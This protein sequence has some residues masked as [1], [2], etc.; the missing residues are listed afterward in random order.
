M[1]NESQAEPVL[2][3]DILGV[4]KVY[5]DGSVVHTHNDP[6]LNTA[7][8]EKPLDKDG[9]VASK[10]VI[11]DPDIDLWVRIYL[12]PQRRTHMPVI[13]YFHGGGFCSISPSFSWFHSFCLK[14]T[15][16]VDA[17]IVSVNYRLAP[18]HRLPTAYN[19]SEAAIEWV[20]FQLIEK[21]GGKAA[22]PWLN[23]H[24]EFSNVYLMGDSSGANIVH[25]LIM[26]RPLEN[27]KPL[28]IRGALLLQPYFAGEEYT[29]SELKCPETA[30][31]NMK[32]HDILWSLALPLGA[33]RDHP[34]CN[35][36]S[37]QSP[38]LS[39][40]DIPPLMAFVGDK[41]YGRDR[42][43]EYCNALKK[44]GKTVD[45]IMFDEEEHAF[46]LL[47]AGGENSKKIRQYVASFISSHSLA[48]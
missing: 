24:A 27:W 44:C 15:S 47:K 17:I 1:A 46:Y 4:L 3:E 36:F 30:F 28:Q 35:P 32:V 6:D 39:K 18:E 20:R 37:P 25:H 26:R 29:E 33:N 43:L 12:P 14:M 7:A 41:C 42:S 40:A 38:S 16:S 45:V 19:D 22:E 23:S 13:V 8:S 2:V 10:D 5:S 34:F 48:L 31:L 11:L 9:G 21:R